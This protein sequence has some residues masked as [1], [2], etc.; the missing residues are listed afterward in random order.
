M[1]SHPV[2]GGSGCDVVMTVTDSAP[3][4]PT[5]VPHLRRALGELRSDGFGQVMVFTQYTDTMDFL[6]RELG[7]D[8]DRRLMCF[9]GRGGRDTVRR[10]LM[11]ND[12]P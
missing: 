3:V 7:R 11:A 10:R 12:R 9:S 4:T 8:K 6:R 1:G 5:A 2:P